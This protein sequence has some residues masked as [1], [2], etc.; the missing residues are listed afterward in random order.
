MISLKHRKGLWVHCTD[1]FKDT[2]TLTWDIGWRW[3]FFETFIFM[4]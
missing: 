4:L 1:I 3:L 2:E